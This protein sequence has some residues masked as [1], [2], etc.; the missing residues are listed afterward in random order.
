MEINE[1]IGPISHAK[2]GTQ[3]PLK[4][5]IKIKEKN[6]TFEILYIF[7]L[8]NEEREKQHLSAGGLGEGKML[9]VVVVVGCR[10]KKKNDES[11][12]HIR[13]RLLFF[14]QQVREEEEEG[15]LWV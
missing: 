11:A 7:F 13:D 8:I 10:R 1:A 6:K 15:F 12:R 14:S 3:R 9:L 5:I 4:K 2:K